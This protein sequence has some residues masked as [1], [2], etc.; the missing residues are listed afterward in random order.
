MWPYEGRFL[1]RVPADRIAGRTAGTVEP[2]DEH[3]CVLTLRGDD[4]HL[5]SVVV[6]FL[7]VDFEVLE[8]V[9]LKG[10]AAHPRA[11]PTLL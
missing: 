1:L 5:M 2:V 6:A 11:A 10:K 8:P 9:E 4:L 7:D 3:S